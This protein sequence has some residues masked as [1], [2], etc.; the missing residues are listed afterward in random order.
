MRKGKGAAAPLMCLAAVLGA[1]QPSILSHYFGA[2]CVR[3]PATVLASSAF[4]VAMAGGVWIVWRVSC[5][6]APAI[7]YSGN[8]L[9]YLLTRQAPVAMSIC[10][11]AI[12]GSLAF[13][14]FKYIAAIY[15]EGLLIDPAFAG[16]DLRAYPKVIDRVLP[17]V[18]LSRPGWFALT[19]TVSVPAFLGLWTRASFAACWL[20]ALYL[21]SHY[22]AQTHGWSH[23][24][25]PILLCAIPFLL[26]D[27]RGAL[28]VG[29]AG[30][31]S[32]APFLPIFVGQVLLALFYFGAFYAKMMIG[33]LS[34]VTSDHLANSMDLAWAG[35]DRPDVVAFLQEDRYFTALAATA[36]LL[37]QAIPILTFFAGDK[38]H[39]RA[40]E[41]VIFASGCVLIWQ[42]MGNLWPWYWWSA[43]ALLFVDWDY[44][45][46]K[47]TFGRRVDLLSAR[48]GFGW[49]ALYPA[50][51]LGA[52]ASQWVPD[53]LDAY[54]FLD[55]LSFYAQP[56][57]V[58]PYDGPTPY[59]IDRAGI[60]AHDP[61]CVDVS[62]CV[63]AR[64][65]V[66][67][68]PNAAFAEMVRTQTGEGTLKLL[69]RC[70]RASTGPCTA[71]PRSTGAAAWRT[72]YL[73]NGGRGARVYRAGY[74]AIASPGL[75]IA[76]QSDVNSTRFLGRHA[77]EVIRVD[78][79]VLDPARD[80][81]SDLGTTG[82]DAMHR[83]LGAA[84]F[85]VGAVHLA[86]GRQIPMILRSDCQ[87]RVSPNV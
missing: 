70:N 52:T 75:D 61:G 81:M 57:D 38:P 69:V 9:D 1:I 50:L 77:R 39:L 84:C 29:R 73:L 62:G 51:Y 55:D 7:A 31:E 53:A 54:P 42:F 14:S 64:P 24:E 72:L 74:T 12:V 10:R 27:M 33:G 80:R 68:N 82:P 56:H 18:D 34:W 59:L 20:V 87:W 13:C 36:H 6:T 65:I 32:D 71:L 58:W 60:G 48:G 37:L 67:A 46:G 5:S 66:F 2:G 41:G 19:L 86:D 21:I 44:F 16:L 23:G 30:G 35:K 47:V 40:V 45:C 11:M 83:R 43:I 15:E 4:F 85:A 76:V 79:E 78:I 3:D 26:R 17:F 63:A 8:Y 25:A 22:E 49:L 28:F